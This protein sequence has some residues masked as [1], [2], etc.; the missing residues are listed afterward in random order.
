MKR[1][2]LN[3]VFILIS[4]AIVLQACNKEDDDHHENENETKISTYQSDDSHN[5]GS[6][7][8]SCHKSG[9]SG[10]GWFTIAGTVYDS[11]KSSI[12]PGSTIKLFS[13]PNESGTLI[14]SVQVDKNGNFYTTEKIDFQMDLYVSAEGT[15]SIHHMITKLPNGQ[16]NSCHG[17]STDK[18]WVK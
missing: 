8:M 11:T 15:S 17:T 6:N 3:L 10:E 1:P 7:C 14:S 9:G 2:I 16:C 18:I 13:G 4:A 12:Y 5:T